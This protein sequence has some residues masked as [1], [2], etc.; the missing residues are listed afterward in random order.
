MPIQW[1]I[2][3]AKTYHTLGTMVYYGKLWQ[4]V[5]N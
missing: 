4:T 2:Y 3:P 5:V 1:T